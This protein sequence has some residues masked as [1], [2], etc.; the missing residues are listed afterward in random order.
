VKAPSSRSETLRWGNHKTTAHTEAV[1]SKAD[2]ARAENELWVLSAVSAVRDEDGAT[3][4]LGDDERIS[5]GDLRCPGHEGIGRDC[6]LRTADYGRMIALPATAA[7]DV[8]PCRKD[9]EHDSKTPHVVQEST[10]LAV[11]ALCW[12]PCVGL[13]IRSWWPHVD[14]PA[15]VQRPYYKQQWD[16]AGYAEYRG[17]TA[18]ADVPD[19][20]CTS[21]TSLRDTVP[22]AESASVP[23]ARLWPCI[24]CQ[25]HFFLACLQSATYS[26]DRSLALL[27]D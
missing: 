21:S 25:Q 7:R 27:V 12:A 17:P 4:L 10:A 2:A 20:I 11:V 18:T 13:E 1:S 22:A 23:G 16:D 14:R 26:R 5:L 19:R 15:A 8:T 24:V 9:F 6:G 3:S